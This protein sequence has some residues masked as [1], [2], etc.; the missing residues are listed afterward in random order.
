MSC[1]E[2]KKDIFSSFCGSH[3][4]GIPDM[5][6]NASTETMPD[7]M[8]GS[9]KVARDQRVNID[10]YLDEISIPAIEIPEWLPKLPG[11]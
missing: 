11:P 6:T 5:G 8:V 10:V 1:Q 3:H 7:L 4:T 2:K 9:K